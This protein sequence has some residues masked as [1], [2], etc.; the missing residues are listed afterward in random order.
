MRDICPTGLFAGK[1]PNGQPYLTDSDAQK[2]HNYLHRNGGVVSYDLLNSAVT[3]LW[4][5]LTWYAN[6]PESA[7]FRGEY[8]P[9]P[10]K[11]MS[12]EKL[13]EAGLKRLSDG[14]VV[15][16]APED[17]APVQQH[18]HREDSKPKTPEELI[19]AAA[20]NLLASK[21]GYQDWDSMSQEAKDSL[22]PFKQQCDTMVVQLRD[23]RI[24]H[25]MTDELRGVLAKN[26]R[27]GAIDWE[28][29]LAERKKILAVIENQRNQEYRPTAR[30][31]GG[32]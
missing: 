20:R 7:N 14:R 21:A 4:S 2:I 23:G 24:D 8:A 16:M 22:N 26:A 17:Y 10:Y 18:N 15:P 1:H 31:N 12:A 32:R 3:Q 6:D 13:R 19:R 27:T 25:K 29:T 11:N 9:Q 28:R 5:S 30:N